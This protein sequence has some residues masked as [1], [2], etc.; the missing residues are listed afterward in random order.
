MKRYLKTFLLVGILGVGL[1][2]PF[3]NVSARTKKMSEKEFEV[4]LN[5]EERKAF[6]LTKKYQKTLMDADTNIPY[7][8]KYF[9]LKKKTQNAKT[10]SAGGGAIPGSYDSREHG[11]RVSVKNQGDAGTCWAHAI[12]DS[13]QSGY[14][15]RTGR[16]LD[17]SE[18]QMAYFAYQQPVDLLSLCTGDVVTKKIKK[19]G[20]IAELGSYDYYSGGNKWFTMFSFAKGIGGAVESDAQYTQ[21]QKIL[22]RGD[23]AILNED[24]AYLANDFRL[25]STDIVSVQQPELLK[26][27]IMQYGAGTIS[28]ISDE[29][30]YDYGEFNYYNP[31]DESYYDLE[32]K[33]ISHEVSIVG[34]D[35]NYPKNQFVYEPEHDGAWLV[36][37]SWG[38]QW[39]NDGYFWMS[40]DETSI[41]DE[42]VCFYDIE[43]DNQYDYV[44]QYDGA[45]SLEVTPVGKYSKMAN[46]F[47]AQKEKEELK[48]V[49]FFTVE[50]DTDYEVNVY[51]GLQDDAN[52]ESG[53]VAATL[54]GSKPMPGYCTLDL[55]EA[56]PLKKGESF[57]VV[58]RQQVSGRNT[59]MYIDCNADYKWVMSTCSAKRGQSFLYGDGESGWKDISEDGETNV[60][61]KAFTVDG[62]SSDIDSLKFEQ[63]NYTVATNR[64]EQLFVYMGEEQV[65][66]R[67]KLEFTAEDTTILSVDGK[68]TVYGK[69][70]GATSVKVRC[71]NAE[72]VCQVQVTEEPISE[73]KK[74]EGFASKDNPVK[75]MVGQEYSFSFEK[76]PV[77][78]VGTIEWNASYLGELD[79]YDDVPVKMNQNGT[80][81]ATRPGSYIITVTAVNGQQKCQL[82]F[83]AEASLDRTDCGKDISLLQSSRP[84]GKNELKVYTYKGG[85]KEKPLK[86]HFTEQSKLQKDNSYVYVFDGTTEVEDSI[87]GYLLYGEMYGD[88]LIGTYTAEE[89]IDQT[90]YV[91]GNSFSVVLITKDEDD[92]EYGFCV[93][94]V[95]VIKPITYLK[96]PQ[97]QY[98]WTVGDENMQ[99]VPTIRPVDTNEKVKFVSSKP[100]VADVDENGNITV[101]KAGTVTITAQ[102]EY[103]KKKSSATVVI[104]DTETY[105]EVAFTQE[106]YT[107]NRNDELDLTFTQPV[108]GYDIT[109]ESSAPGKVYVDENGHVIAAGVIENATIRA[110]VRIA[111][112]QYEAATQITVEA[113]DVMEEKD[114]QSIHN[115]V[116]GMDEYYTYVAAEGTEGIRL[117]F[118][119]KSVLAEDGDY[120]EIL[121]GNQ[122]VIQKYQ[123][124]E[125]KNEN[126][127]VPGNVAQIHLVT[128]R[129]EEED[130]YYDED[131][132]YDDGEGEDDGEYTDYGFRVKRIETGA[133]A[134]SIELEDI[135]LD[136]T[137]YMANSA[138][139]KATLT[140]SNAIDTVTYK[141][142]DESVASIGKYGLL[143]AK[144]S[145]TTK[146]TATTASGLQ[147][148]ANITVKGIP[149]ESLSVEDKGTKITDITM[150]RG[151]EK[152]YSIIVTPQNHTEY[153]DVESD[154]ESIAYGIHCNDGSLY[155]EAKSVGDTTL[156]VKNRSGSCSQ[157][158]HVHVEPS[159][160]AGAG[161]EIDDVDDFSEYEDGNKG[162][163]ASEMTIE[164][165]QS[166]HPYESDSRILWSYYK[167]D[168]ESVTITFNSKTCF[169]DKYDYLY[170]YTYDGKGILGY[171][172]DSLANQ[173]ITIPGPGFRIVLESDDGGEEYGF[174]LSDLKVKM[175]ESVPPT[176]SK[177][178]D[179]TKPGD[180]GSG[181]TD[182]P[183]QTP[184]DKTQITEA[185]NTEKAVG[186]IITVSNAQYKITKQAGNATGTVTFLK[187]TK[188]KKKLTSLT[189][190]NTV[191]IDGKTYNVTAI[192]KNACKN[193]SKLKKLTIGKNVKSIGVGAFSGC[194]VLKSIKIQSTLLTKKTIGKKAF[195]GIHKKAV[196]KVPKKKLKEYK[197]VLYG[198]GVSKSVKIK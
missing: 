27:M 40:Y 132:E 33:V 84:Y 185:T 157:V 150:K 111:D 48:A 35:D 170:L 103:S 113:P 136:F 133:L 66:D 36:K 8:Q 168:A 146:V 75:V 193:Y 9:N 129:D 49:S 131:A 77:Y 87:S 173:T 169:E 54:K 90:L 188:S 6:E 194:K 93:D 64:P 196:I 164:A 65:N 171:T 110:K 158:I 34:W 184:T 80:F 29:Y 122:K 41:Q 5:E 21:M 26:Q 161:F 160:D 72:A 83:Y 181:K 105:D 125:M 107:M 167:K 138:K 151:E 79:E 163:D 186:T 74:E 147:T 152:Y 159:S 143:W 149:M 118:D 108:D 141:I 91:D 88:T 57:A 73:L 95:E 182:V 7:P 63:D 109:Y 175:K 94:S 102:G 1:L 61:V 32:E 142:E 51:T 190:P 179:T 155:I 126:I 81:M 130:E 25:D 69:K 39:G 140:P 18:W 154:D 44:Y 11:V 47:E 114:M 30:C 50:N 97:Q 191:K 23:N 166:L 62:T 12:L 123:Y 135:S 68:G 177:P 10:R 128:Q 46:I 37:N 52:P 197:K 134:K 121:D 22:I 28:Y 144:T 86:I 59:Q 3:E 67:T 53:I 192:E 14:M 16:E 45:M 92:A 78:G 195:S 117:F 172:G 153:I 174:A 56:I 101:K 100:S 99:L 24:K 31:K 13:A 71:G 165:L 176:P 96:F 156:T 198:C 19:T 38:T 60:R 55:E 58:V 178:I 17:L 106:S 119:N 115:Y 148:T 139:L 145:G 187:S 162:V 124:W 70:K 189:I 183:T 15:K 42:A 76:E 112:K 4:T 127:T 120:V 82:Q 116:D 20:K 43:D 2:Q 180:T 85:G 137:D 89:L 104:K 98:V